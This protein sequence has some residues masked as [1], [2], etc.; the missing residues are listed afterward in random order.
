MP[1]DIGGPSMADITPPIRNDGEAK[2]VDDTHYPLTR[3]DAFAAVAIEMKERGMSD[4]RKR[5][6]DTVTKTVVDILTHVNNRIPQVDDHGELK[7]AYAGSVALSLYAQAER[8]E[9][10]SY[11]SPTKRKEDIQLD[12]KFQAEILFLLP[13]LP[14]DIDTVNGPKWDR[15]IA[16]KLAAVH[17]ET[18]PLYQQLIPDKP[19]K[20]FEFD[21]GGVDIDV[22]AP[23][24]ERYVRMHIKDTEFV[25]VH[26]VS[27]FA[28]KIEWIIQ[29]QVKTKKPEDT[30]TQKAHTAESMIN[31]WEKFFKRE[32][33]VSETARVLEMTRDANYTCLMDYF[34]KHRD[35]YPK[36]YVLAQEV[37]AVLSSRATQPDLIARGQDK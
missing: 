13:T 22:V 21:K 11:E 10:V 6:N 17:H 34:D 26:P 12:P 2:P 5:Y 1:R 25:A 16:L 8:M 32:D 27:F 33:I 4:A 3:D 29:G 14:G 23:A 28:H 30:I 15:D 35:T 31:I 37:R 20:T 36:L 24:Q 9:E 18:D 19:G 7:Y